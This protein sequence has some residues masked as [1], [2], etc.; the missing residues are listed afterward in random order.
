MKQFQWLL[1]F[2]FSA[3]GSLVGAQEQEVFQITL[4]PQHR[5]VENFDYLVVEVIDARA[6]TSNVGEARVGE[7]NKRQPIRL[8][9]GVENTFKNYINASLESSDSAAQVRM[10][11]LDFQ[12]GEVIRINAQDG[13]ALLEVRFDVLDQEARVTNS[14][15]ITAEHLESGT[16][17]TKGHEVRAKDVIIK[18]LEQL[19]WRVEHDSSDADMARTIAEEREALGEITL[20]PGKWKYKYEGKYYS[21]LNQMDFIINQ[22]DDP[23]IKRLYRKCERQ[24]RTAIVLGTFG[25]VLIGAPLGYAVI[26]G[27]I[28]YPTLTAG[29][30]VT[31]AAFILEANS[32]KNFK[33]VIARYNAL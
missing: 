23:E 14:Y 1:V 5:Y 33:R 6:D 26:T 24:H 18:S 30:F 4:D 17:V 11:V 27:F 15:T 21:N 16:D 28:F 29:A 13:T 20:H 22:C 19:V 9:G 25:G 3:L 8:R 32:K 31:A 7:F 10:T 2:A 12:L